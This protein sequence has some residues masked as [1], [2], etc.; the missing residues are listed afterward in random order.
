MG[1]PSLSREWS[2]DKGKNN[3][4]SLTAFGMTAFFLLGVLS[5]GQETSQ[6]RAFPQKCTGRAP[7]HAGCLV[8]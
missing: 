1:H 8:R 6:A 4:R 5:R 2:K 3:R 7:G